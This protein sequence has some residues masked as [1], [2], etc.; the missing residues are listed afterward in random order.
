LNT[1]SGATAINGG[2][3]VLTGA[4]QAT[5]SII[6]GTPLLAVP[7]PGYALEVF[8]GNQLRLVQTSVPSAYATW[9][10]TNATS[11]NPD[12]HFDGDGVSNAVE[13]MLGGN[14]NTHDLGKLP[15]VSSSGANL[16]FTF[17]RDQASIAASTAVTVELG[18]T[19]GSWSGSYAVPDGAAANNPGVSVVKSSPGAGF[20]TV[21]L[22]V[23]RAPDT[24]KF[25]RLKIVITP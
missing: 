15:T 18:T 8:A 3:L 14:K 1:Y 19:L 12:N 5:T 13:F 2:T 16:V 22:T 23:P 17:I 20:D 21:T 11:G 9:A 24:T 25:A 4:T 10:S 6:T 7:V